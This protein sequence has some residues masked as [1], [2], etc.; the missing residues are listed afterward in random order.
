MTCSSSSARATALLR[1]A[2]HQGDEKAPG[3]LRV[4]MLL[5]GRAVG[6]GFGARLFVEEAR[7]ALLRMP[8]PIL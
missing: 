5:R 4:L 6:V 8:P 3:A 7:A 2:D 1:A